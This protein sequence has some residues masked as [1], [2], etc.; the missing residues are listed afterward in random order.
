MSELSSQFET[1]ARNPRATG[2]SVLQQLRDDEVP[3]MAGSIAYQAF[4]SLIPLLV[5]LFFVVSVVGDDV[6][7]TRLVA[8]TQGFLPDAAQRLLTDAIAGPGA[9]SV[10]ASLIGLVTLLWGAFRIFR[11]LDTAFSEIYET[12]DENSLLDQLSDGAVVLG[13]VIAAT[14]AMVAVG[15][16]FAV[17]EGPFAR[18]V[19]LL[20]LV[21]G[22]TV[23]FLPVYRYFPD[24][25]LSW[26]EAVPGAVFGALGWGILQFLFQ[27]YVALSGKGGSVI[28]AV[29]LLLTWLYLG[30][31]VL[32][33]GGVLNAVL[34][35]EG[36]PEPK[37]SD[38]DDP[39]LRRCVER[40]HRERDRRQS[41]QHEVA[42]YRRRLA[43]ERADTSPEVARLRRENYALR[44]RLR[45][46]HKSLPKRSL[47][48]LAGAKPSFAGEGASPSPGAGTDS[49]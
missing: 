22:L 46:E 32:L 20:A 16:A 41:L 12:D 9:G 26:A 24:A 33:V 19:N 25:N 3:F 28:G 44:R 17:F 42:R 45:W 48:R 23:V 14:L 4:V 34:L 18:A 5:L 47:L 11:G 21:A 7:A 8:L 10:S 40:F 29:L 6:L 35:G 31:L 37:T 15:S 1:A 38:D 43:S 39:R 27:F 36:D 2:E 30:G 13:V 49:R